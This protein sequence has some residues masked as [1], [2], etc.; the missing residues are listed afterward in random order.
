MLLKS[1][2]TSGFLPCLLKKNISNRDYKENIMRLLVISLCL[3]LASEIYAHSTETKQKKHIP[4]SMGINLNEPQSQVDIVTHAQI[5]GDLAKSFR[6]FDESIFNRVKELLETKGITA[7]NFES[8]DPL[9]KSTF[10][11]E[12]LDHDNGHFYTINRD[13]LD[14]K[15]EEES[16][17]LK[18]YQE[19]DNFKIRA[20]V[21]RFAQKRYRKFSEFGITVNKDKTVLLTKGSYVYTKGLESAIAGDVPNGIYPLY[22]EGDVEVDIEGFATVVECPE[23]YQAAQHCLDIQIPETPSVDGVKITFTAN[24]DTHLKDFHLIL[25]TVDHEEVLDGK[26]VFNPDY[27]KY[28]EPFS[29]FRVMNMM[30]SSPKAPF[31]CVTTYVKA[32]DVYSLPKQKLEAEYLTHEVKIKLLEIIKDTDLALINQESMDLD[33]IVKTFKEI[34]NKDNEIFYTEDEIENIEVIVKQLLSED[35]FLNIMTLEYRIQQSKDATEPL[36]EKLAVLR[37]KSLEY[38]WNYVYPNEDYGNC[39]MKYARTSENRAILTDQFWGNSYITPEER[40]R[41][42]PYEVIVALINKTKSNVWVNIPHNA[43]INYVTDISDYFNE[44]INKDSNIFIEL[45]NEVWNGGFAG[46]KYFT[47]LSKHRYGYYVTEF[48]DQFENYLKT[49]K[50]KVVA[51]R[52]LRKG[53]LKHFNQFKKEITKE[54]ETFKSCKDISDFSNLV[55]NLKFTVNGESFGEISKFIQSS[56]MGD[57]FTNNYLRDYKL[58]EKGHSLNEITKLLTQD[59]SISECETFV[60]N[61]YIGDDEFI[62]N[63]KYKKGNYF[64]RLALKIPSLSAYW[65]GYTSAAK[66]KIK[67]QIE[68]ENGKYKDSL[69]DRYT[70]IKE[71]KNELHSPDL[72]YHYSGNEIRDLQEKLFKEFKKGWDKRIFSKK[73][74]DFN[75]NAQVFVLKNLDRAYQTMAQMAYV[76]RLDQIAKIWIDSGINENKLIFTLATK[77]NNPNLTQSML[78]YAVKRKSIE[79]VDAIATPAYFFGCFGDLKVENTIIKPHKFGPC[80]G[81]SKGVLNAKTAKDIIDILKDPENPKGIKNIRKELIAHKKV[82]NKTDK[83]I[84]L[85]AY[86][87]GHHLALA[88]LGRNQRKYFDSHPDLKVEKLALFKDAIEHE[89]MGEITKDLYKVWLEE[90][91]KQFNNFYMPQSF[92]EWGSLG[93]SLSLSDMSTPRYLAASEYALIFKEKEAAS[94]RSNAKIPETRRKR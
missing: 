73:S 74:F 24:S 39:L 20:L 2:K 58:V 69:V 59:S 19:L 12:Y 78:D 83:R 60:D 30:I 87:G 17:S 75:I 67:I 53:Y 92:H 47:G 56:S 70:Y 32:R 40:W 21:N 93:L 55:N 23:K 37:Q 33:S 65:L 48:L 86:E 54:L 14:D 18:P 25:P 45:S 41:G 1:F 22:F 85:V 26:I 4:I 89:G 13:P 62:Q 80:N 38:N 11:D 9:V 34:K 8:E 35:D 44:N 52:N 84:Q 63:I 82:I 29:T 15:K 6:P 36:K 46:Q 79:R 94:I 51:Y 81:I 10:V 27:L 57:N 72:V 90:G 28:I 66:G 64:E 16:F 50:D 61:T 71:N 31:E 42:L 76:D 91:G 88:N 43:S 49:S 7:V 5:V 68:D 3:I 77:Q